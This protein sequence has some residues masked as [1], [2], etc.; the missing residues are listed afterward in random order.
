M[1]HTQNTVNKLYL[2]LRYLTFGVDVARRQHRA[3]RPPCGPIA[4]PR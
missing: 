1:E 3:L 4:L 2:S